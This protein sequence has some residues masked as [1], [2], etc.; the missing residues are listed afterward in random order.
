MKPVHAAMTGGTGAVQAA[1]QPEATAAIAPS[2]EG[3]Y[4]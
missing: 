1:E 3:S 4:T 2:T